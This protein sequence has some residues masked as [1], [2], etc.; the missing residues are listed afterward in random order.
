MFCSSFIDTM[1]FHYTLYDMHFAYN[2]HH[3]KIQEWCAIFPL[4]YCFS[5][6]LLPRC[7]LF[8]FCGDHNHHHGPHICD[9]VILKN[10]I[11][12]E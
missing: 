6:S 8:L 9:F 3:H 7:H 4:M 1:S 12:M 11:Q 10:V 5:R 2:W